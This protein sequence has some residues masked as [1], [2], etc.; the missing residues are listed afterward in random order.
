MVEFK[1]GESQQAKKYKL[2]IFTDETLKNKVHEEDLKSPG[3]VLTENLPEGTYYWQ[4]TALDERGDSTPSSIGRFK[5]SPVKE[6]VI[7]TPD[8][9][10]DW[11]KNWKSRGHVAWAPSSDTY[12]FKSDNQS[13]KIDGNTMMG[14]EGR[15]TLFRPKWIYSGEFIRQSGKVFK[16]E[17][18]SFMKL[19]V[20][21]GW[22]FKSGTHTFSA[23]PA[24]GFGS[25]QS[26]S[27]EN[28]TV[29][30][31]GVSGAIYGGVLRS[32]H[33]L[34]PD[35]GVEGKAS[36]LMG[37]LTEL[38][39]SANVLRTMKDYYLVFGAGI[40]KR[41]YTKSSGE[42]SSLKLNAGLGREF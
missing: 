18:Y 16:K 28:S 2:G 26:Y 19:T 8:Y 24:L 17:E 9:P 38:E 5:F 13:G 21:A 3:F 34:S 42:Q 35:W 37:G 31:S 25:G 1:W 6:E 36:Y 29:T 33:G 20:D 11:Q 40:V 7:A 27:I 10:G 23:G 22:I 39:I 12:N 4:V 30:A 32:F 41:E 15:G 14:L